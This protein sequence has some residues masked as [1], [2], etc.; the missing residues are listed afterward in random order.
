[1]IY[2]KERSGRKPAV[3]RGYMMA[4]SYRV[5]FSLTHDHKPIGIPH[6]G[7]VRWHGLDHGIG[8]PMKLFVDAKAHK[9]NQ[10]GLLTASVVTQGGRKW[11]TR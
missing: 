3:G 9:I 6:W 11:P 2:I 1:M 7:T 4:F 8:H 5:V 10:V